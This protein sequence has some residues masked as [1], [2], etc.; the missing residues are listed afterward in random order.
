LKKEK[1]TIFL[2]THNLDEAQRICDRIGILNTKLMV[3]GA[4]ET[5]MESLR[6]RRISVKLVEVNEA[7][8]AALARLGFD[9]VTIDGN[10]LVIDVKDP[11]RMI[12]A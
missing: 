5:L 3:V 2:N 8:V 11:K 1:K 9:K 10:S 6:G 12:R 4:P 7:I